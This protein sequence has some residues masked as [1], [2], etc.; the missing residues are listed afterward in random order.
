MGEHTAPKFPQEIID[1]YAALGVDL[2]ALFSAGHLGERMGVTVV[3]ASAER[4]VGTMPVEGNTQPYGLLHGGAS[5]VL[6]ETLGSIG[7]MLHGGATKLAVG[8]DLNCTH[9]RGVRSGLVTGVAT[10]VHR[11]RSTATY[12]IAITDEQDKR[13]CTA[14]LTCM[15]RDTPRPDAA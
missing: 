2:P 8:V 1:E 11:G 6:A 12:E 15:L 3:E 4:V 10:P 7:S 14:R 9:H 5:A 13:V